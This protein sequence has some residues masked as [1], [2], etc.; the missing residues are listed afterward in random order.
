MYACIFYIID[1]TNWIAYYSVSSI[2]F[3]ASAFIFLRERILDAISIWRTNVRTC[4]ASNIICKL[5]P[6]CKVYG[7]KKSDYLKWTW[8]AALESIT[9]KSSIASAF[10][11][12]ASWFI[13]T[14]SIWM[15]VIYSVA[16]LK[17]HYKVNYHLLNSSEWASAN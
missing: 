10:I 12:S 8:S 16:T 2:S 4:C 9:R 3:F 1:F 7:W 14:L 13:N 5:T 17:S 15:A 11:L 6:E